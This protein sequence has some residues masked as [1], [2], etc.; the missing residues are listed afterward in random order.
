MEEKK[1]SGYPSI[2]KPWKKW[3]RNDPIRKIAKN[4]TVYEM[5][6]ESNKKHPDDAALGYMGIEWTFQKLKTITD[7]AAYA[8]A[9]A[10]LKKGD[11]VL[12]GIANCPQAVVALLALN[13]L[14]AVSQWFDI[15]TGEKSIAEYARRSKCKYIIIYDMLL[16]KIEKIIN[17]INVQKI[18]VTNPCDFL[19]R[20]KQALY[21]AYA[22]KTGT[23]FKMPA[24]TRYLGFKEF[25]KSGDE[26][27]E[28]KCASYDSKA[29]AIMIQSSG[30][31]GTPKIITHS[32]LSA[33][34]A[35]QKLSYVDLPLGRKRT[36]LVALPPWI[37][38]CLGDAILFPLAIGMKI[39]LAPD[40]E[41]D[42]VYRYIGKF[43]I[44]FAAPR[45]Y[46]YLQDKIP[47]LT[48]RQRKGFSKIECL[49]SGGDRI[50]VEENREFEK[51]FECPLVNGY[52]NN[53]GWGALTV[54]PASHNK[55]GTVGVPK[56]DDIIISYDNESQ[57]E[58]KY[59]E[60]GEICALTDTAFLY[61]EGRQKETD[62]I[63]KR[64]PDGKIWIHTGD[65]GYIDED[66]YVHL[67]GRMRRV[68]IRGG[69]KLSADMIEE[70]IL[71]NEL[72]KEC[73]V[74]GVKDESEGEVPMAFILLNPELGKDL[75]AAEKAILD[76]LSIKMK[77]NEIPKWF[78]FV[79]SL[80][81]T[82]NG[83]YDF[84]RLEGMGEEY[85]KGKGLL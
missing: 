42:I 46:R 64:H 33:T 19:P 77:Q 3:Y 18:L 20:I 37:A 41:L 53:E 62:E 67:E 51:A 6:F 8:F 65:I 60:C 61:Y 12:I 2:D 24:D 73:V 66:G 74:V 34:S 85:L 84:R 11:I 5:V 52:G 83:K 15:R 58:L 48:Y 43:T 57:T 25:I 27:M 75:K 28:L 23:F 40:F 82:E 55:Y 26:K 1:Q 81:Y 80:P 76:G 38:Y 14:G 71:E 56:Y 63:K 50:S 13:K 31:T 7:Q 69:F 36:V 68:I 45:N 35:A 79:D 17:D 32:N 21:K 47:T 9:K 16:P 59:G 4:Q 72:V 54:N 78:E 39:E 49:V 44:A 10:G 70:K 30:T 29:P 22:K